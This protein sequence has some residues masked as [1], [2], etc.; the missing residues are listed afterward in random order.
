LTGIFAAYLETLYISCTAYVVGYFACF[1]LPYHPGHDDLV[2]HIISLAFRHFKYREMSVIIHFVIDSF[3][4]LQ[5]TLCVVCHIIVSMIKLIWL[6]S[7][8]VIMVYCY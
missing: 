3:T 1:Q 6:L 2:T 8:N 7:V 5:L 4:Y